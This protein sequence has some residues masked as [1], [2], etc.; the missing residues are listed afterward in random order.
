LYLAHIII[1]RRR[2]QIVPSDLQS[3]AYP[4]PR[5]DSGMAALAAIEAA[6]V[7]HL[8]KEEGFST[9]NNTEESQETLLWLV[10]RIWYHLSKVENAL[11]DT[12]KELRKGGKEAP[13]SL[14]GVELLDVAFFESRASI[15]E[16]VVSQSW[17]LLSEEEPLV[18]F[19]KNLGQVIVPLL[20]FDPPHSNSGLCPDWNSVPEKANFLVTTG[21]SISRLLLN[22]KSRETTRLAKSIQWKFE[23]DNSLFSLH[24]YDVPNTPC[25]HVQK[26][27]SKKPSTD[28]VV[29]QRM[30]DENLNGAF[31][32][33]GGKLLNKGRTYTLLSPDNRHNPQVRSGK[34]N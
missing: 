31:I 4:E 8:P 17:A 7:W 19:C 20:P 14:I 23:N 10:Q 11:P 18:F 27:L 3:K 34:W 6:G 30:V 5:A 16:A 12:R 21:H 9:A 2:E 26:L 25:R 24:Q 33:G 28:Q 13:K 15:K 1:A 32:F 29:L 22:N